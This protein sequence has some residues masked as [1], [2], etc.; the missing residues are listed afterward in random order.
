MPTSGIPSPSVQ[1]AMLTPSV[2]LA[3]WMRGSMAALSYIISIEIVR[4][5]ER[6]VPGRAIR[7][8]Q[9]E[10]AGGEGPLVV[11]QPSRLSPTSAE[12]HRPLLR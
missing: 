2:V 12:Q 7:A 1:K 10:A 6:F 8:P 9:R 5:W 3:Y 11:G 4:R